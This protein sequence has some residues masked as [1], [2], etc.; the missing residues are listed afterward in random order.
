MKEISCYDQERVIG[1]YSKELEQIVC[2]FHTKLDTPIENVFKE[3]VYNGTI[4]NFEDIEVHHMCYYE[5]STGKV[6]S[7]EHEILIK[8]ADFKWEELQPVFKDQ[9]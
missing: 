8:G 1:L 7:T 5:I 9:E 2:V 3:M 6:I 4:Q